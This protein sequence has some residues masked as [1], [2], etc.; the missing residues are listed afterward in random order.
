MSTTEARLSDCNFT[1][2]I[3]DEVDVFKTENEIIVSKKSQ[4]AVQ[5]VNPE[6]MEIYL[7][8]NKI[9]SYCIS[10]L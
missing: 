9:N 3:G 5:G 6:G 2:A 7:S 4:P 1:P 8:K 10:V